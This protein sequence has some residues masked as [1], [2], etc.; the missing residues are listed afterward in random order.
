MGKPTYSPSKRRR[1]RA[2]GFRARN[3]TAA[4]QDILRRRRAHGRKR[5][6]PAG[7]EKKY[8]RHTHSVVH[9]N[10]NQ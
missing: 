8:R 3:K 10:R 7:A 5:L 9:G 4:G 2:F 1:T 6:V